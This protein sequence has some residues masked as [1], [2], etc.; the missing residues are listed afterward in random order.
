MHFRGWYSDCNWYWLERWGT[1]LRVWDPSLQPASRSHWASWG[2]HHGCPLA[3]PRYA[4]PPLSRGCFRTASCRILCCGT[5]LHP[6][7]KDNRQ[8]KKKIHKC[9]NKQFAFACDPC[10]RLFTLLAGSVASPMSYLSWCA[11]ESLLFQLIL[12]QI[13]CP[14]IFSDAI[15]ADVTIK[16]K[17][18]HYILHIYWG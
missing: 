2:W 10:D 12:R 4:H 15:L 17:E 16:C 8:I 14:W 18:E 9:I 5:E 1:H 7:G 6:A 13:H 11:A 3:W